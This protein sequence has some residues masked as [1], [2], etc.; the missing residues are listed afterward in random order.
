M[1]RNKMLNQILYLTKIFQVMMIV[2]H[3]VAVMAV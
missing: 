3:K 1:V 2:V